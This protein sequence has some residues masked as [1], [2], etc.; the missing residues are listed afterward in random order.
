[1]D[2]AVGNHDVGVPEHFAR[3]GDGRIL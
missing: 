2:V 1:V 3:H